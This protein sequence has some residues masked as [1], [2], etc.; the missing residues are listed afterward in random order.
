M[1]STANPGRWSHESF[2]EAVRQAEKSLGEGGVPIGSSLDIAGRLVA[3]GH[4]L[5]VQAGD[6]IAHGEMSCLRNAGR[7]RS[8]RDAALYTTLAPCSMCTGA[9]LLF[10]IPLVV[11]GEARTFP[12][13]LDLLRERGVE[14]VVLDDSRCVGLMERFQRAYPQVWAED[15]G[16][17]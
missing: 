3:G 8:Y 4:N 5:R 9:I 16:E 17:E 13:E 11:V 2:E 15:V 7:R 14:V 12:G 1:E 6:P 10:G